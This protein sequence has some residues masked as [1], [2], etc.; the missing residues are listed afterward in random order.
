MILNFFVSLVLGSG[1]T[2]IWSI[3]NGLQ[4]IQL[5]PLFQVKPPGNIHAFKAFFAEIV[6][7][8]VLD[9]MEMIRELVYIPEQIPFSLNF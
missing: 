7:V 3:L 6:S 4:V 1:M 5:L 8:E 9:A 2:Q